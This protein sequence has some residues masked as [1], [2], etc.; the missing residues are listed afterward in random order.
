MS[1]KPYA[2]NCRQGSTFKLNFT[3]KT[4]TGVQ[5]LSNYSGRMQ[6]RPNI[7][8]STKLLDMS[9]S[10]GY[11]TMNNLGQVA[12]RVEASETARL[13][14]GKHV[15]DFE[16]QSADGTV[17]CILKGKFIVEAEVTR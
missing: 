4:P 17:T 14:E 11:I 15:Y 13:P 10:N 6:V 9:T 16:I 5:D 7:S 8:S 3:L 2:L 12:V 1:L